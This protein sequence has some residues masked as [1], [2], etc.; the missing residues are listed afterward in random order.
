MGEEVFTSNSL[1]FLIEKF[2]EKLSF[3]CTVFA[4]QRVF[5]PSPFLKYRLIQA[6]LN[7]KGAAS[8]GV[9]FEELGAGVLSLFHSLS[10]QRLL[11][12]TRSL[13]SLH[14]EALIL[15]NSDSLLPYFGEGLTQED[16]QKKAEGLAFHL[17]KEFLS[18]GKYG[19]AFLKKWL[20]NS[21]WQQTLW[22]KFFSSWNFPYQLLES[23]FKPPKRP[24][25]VHLFNFSFIP[26]LYHQFFQKISPFV[27][28]FYYQFSPCREFWTDTVS[29]RERVVMQSREG[30]DAE[31]DFY[32]KNHN[33]LLVNFGKVMRKNFFFFEERDMCGIDHTTEPSSTLLGHL[34]SDLFEDKESEGLKI[35][36]DTSFEIYPAFS[37]IREVEML[38]LQLAKS[39]FEPRDIQ[40][41]APDISEYAP[42]IKL[43]F[44]AKDSLLPFQINALPRLSQSLFLQGFLDLISLSKTRFTL[45]SVFKVLLHPF[46]LSAFQLEE[47]EMECFRLWMEKLG[48]KWGLDSKHRS[49]MFSKSVYG[50]SMDGTFEKAFDLLLNRLVLIS[51]KPPSW[52]APAPDFSEAESLGKCIFLIR[53]IK[54]DVGR[55]QSPMSLSSWHNFLKVLAA[56]YF[57]VSKEEGSHL[58]FFT[59]K[60][61]L[62]SHLGEQLPT[63]FLISSI[64]RF[65]EN[66]F[67]EKSAKIGSNALNVISFSSI[68]KAPFF[69]AKIICLLGMEEDA[70]PRN[71]AKSSLK[72]VEGDFCPTPGDEDRAAFLQALLIPSHAL[73]I[74]YLCVNPEDGKE[75]LPSLFVQELLAYIKTH[76]LIEGEALSKRFPPLPFHKDS[77][78]LKH[79]KRDY[80]SAIKFYGEKNHTPF[81]PE[82]FSAPLPLLESGEEIVTSLKKLKSFAKH[83]IRFYFN[84]VLKVY[85]DY[86]TQDEEFYFSPLVEAIFQNSAKEQSFKERIN[87]ARL[88]GKLPLGLFKEVAEQKLMKKSVE[89]EK[90]LKH[91][92]INTL[93]SVPISLKI[94]LSNGGVGSVEGVVENVSSKGLLFYG[95]FKEM[96]KIWPEFLALC[97]AKE[98]GFEK[99][100]L[101]LKDGKTFAIKN[102]EEA[103]GYFLSYFKISLKAPSPFLP[104]WVD[105]FLK[106]SEKELEKAILE[107][108]KMAHD[109]YIQSALSHYEPSHLFK[110][111]APLLQHT[112]QPFGLV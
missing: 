1:N 54:E 43:V 16:K 72:S 58:E 111:W 37:K 7:E 18:N 104:V 95:S 77:P 66:A 57:L 68:S 55:L 51:E 70:F 15:E 6:L 13:M 25:E 49:A 94:P 2:R 56:R 85:L 61:E 34:Q 42:Y 52:E 81:I 17:A 60:L 65:L 28:I 26:S 109:P 73:Y 22:N 9:F 103:L 78:S 98:E 100:L 101:C 50:D 110:S 41:F 33:S 69:S 47:Q 20:K 96:I 59:K 23:S 14:L 62:L 32:L 82:Y 53:S 71:E 3:N 108:I 35:E 93:F 91:F 86:E 24:I 89:M 48:V 5:L 11:L 88:H 29:D 107:K 10:D 21:G 39:P 106:K 30:F 46:V 63:L 8:S 44:G 99:K 31:M 45:K 27:S 38:Y 92:E 4:D 12:P 102:A 105:I 97:L 112:F 19:G 90:G 79:F 64:Q 87:E 74:S 80:L 67:K 84:E 36:P 76:F 40:V 75:Q 83:P